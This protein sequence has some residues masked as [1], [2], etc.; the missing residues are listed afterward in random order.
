MTDESFFEIASFGAYVHYNLI[1]D[2]RLTPYLLAGTQVAVYNGA[3]TG[4]KQVIDN[5]FP[6]DNPA[7]FQER[8]SI[9]R[10][11]IQQPTRE[12]ESNA[13]WGGHLGAGAELNLSKTIGVFAEGRYTALYTSYTADLQQNVQF[14]ELNF[15]LSLNLLRDKTR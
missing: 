11:T 10:V 15:G 2:T 12:I 5:Y 6:I 14:V 8:V 1:A 7:N 9:E 4:R 13:A 3:V